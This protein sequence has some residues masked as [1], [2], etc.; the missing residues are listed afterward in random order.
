MSDMHQSEHSEFGHSHDFVHDFSRAERRTRVVIG[1]TVAMMLLEITAG[2]M[3][4]SMALL[5]DGWHMSTHAIAFVMAAVAYHFTRRHAN[6]ARFSF[7][8]GKIGVLGGYSSAIVLAII[9]LAMAGESIHRLFSPLAIHFNEAI[10]IAAL[11]LGVNLVCAFLLKDDPHHHHHDGQDHG[12]HGSNS[13]RHDLNQRAAY[14]HVLADAFTSVLAISALTSGKLF[15]WGWLDP[16][17]GIAGSG[18]VFSWAYTLLRDTGTVLLDVTPESSDL[19]MEIRRAIESDGD[20][21]VTDLHI[22]QVSSGKFAAI[23]SIVGHEPKSCEVYRAMLQEH[24]ELVHV[25]I[26][27]QHCHDHESLSIR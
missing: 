9:A 8:T 20:S 15:G 18:V 17:V 16:V 4:H 10:G 24:E 23:V 22:W 2:V 7:G 12:A 1:I 27:T 25:T 11:G 13:H 6:D 19:P 14:V 26:E 3:S 21:L 5:A